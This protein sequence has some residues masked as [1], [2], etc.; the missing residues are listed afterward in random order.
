M[1]QSFTVYSI[2]VFFHWLITNVM[3]LNFLHMRQMKIKSNTYHS[4]LSM[5]ITEK[6]G[7]V[8]DYP[9]R[10]GGNFYAVKSILFAGEGVMSIVSG[11]ALPLVPLFFVGEW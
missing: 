9:G 2:I 6:R 4:L 3:I 5:F 1:I 7:G 10:E 11:V 8:S